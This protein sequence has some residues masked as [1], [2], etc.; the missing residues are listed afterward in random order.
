MLN[1]QY[2]K[3]KIILTLFSTDDVKVPVLRGPQNTADMF[4][5]GFLDKGVDSSHKQRELFTCTLQAPSEPT[6]P[7]GKSEVKGQS[8]GFVTFVFPSSVALKDHN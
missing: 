6:Q 1:L 8:W 5:Q 7:Q 3:K 4:T 2:N